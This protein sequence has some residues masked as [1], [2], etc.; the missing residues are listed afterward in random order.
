MRKVLNLELAIMLE[1]QNIKNIFAKVYC[2]KWSE[3]FFVINKVKNIE[4]WTYVHSDLNEDEIVGIF[5]EKELQKTNKNEFR[6]DKVKRE[7]GIKYMLNR[8][9]T[10]VLLKVGLIKKTK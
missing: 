8:K 3:E 10:I 7:K 5:Y 9:V 6:V 4:P 1:Y 2:P